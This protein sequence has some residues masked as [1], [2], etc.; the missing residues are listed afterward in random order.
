MAAQHRVLIAAQPGV[1]ELLQRMLEGSAE[2]VTAATPARA[3]ELL[4]RP[5]GIDLIVCTFGFDESRM[6]DFLQE[7]RRRPE[8]R[9]IP[10]LVVRAIR[11]FLS[12]ALIE[13]LGAAARQVGASEFLDIARLDEQAARERLRATVAGL[14]AH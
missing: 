4:A 1:A 6:V 10:F 13:R 2:I 12:D 14:L 9:A 8:T 5:G 11:R 7:V 3:F